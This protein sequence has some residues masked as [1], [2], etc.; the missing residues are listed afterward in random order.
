MKKYADRYLSMY[1]DLLSFSLSGGQPLVQVP[2]ILIPSWNSIL[3]V[4]SNILGEKMNGQ[5]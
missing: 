3:L 4:Q 1:D 2:L 5:I